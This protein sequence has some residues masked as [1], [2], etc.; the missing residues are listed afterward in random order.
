MDKKLI[1]L[2][3]WARAKKSSTSNSLFGQPWE[4]KPPTHRTVPKYGSH[5]LFNGM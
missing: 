4:N 5:K 2:R 1:F 3:S